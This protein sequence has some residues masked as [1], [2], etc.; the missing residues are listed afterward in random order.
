VIIEDVRVHDCHGNGINLGQDVNGVHIESCLIYSNGL[1]SGNGIQAHG[2]GISNVVISGCTIHSN[3]DNGISG[4]G[5]NIRVVGNYVYGHASADSGIKFTDSDGL[6]AICNNVTAAGGGAISLENTTSCVVTAN[7]V[8]DSAHGI[9]MTDSE[10]FILTGNLARL[11]DTGFSLDGRPVGRSGAVVSNNIAMDNNANGIESVSMSNSVFSGN[12]SV[13]NGASAGDFAGI[14]V[15]GT[16]GAPVENVLMN[17]NECVDTR[18]DPGNNQKYGI[19]IEYADKSMISDS[20]LKGANTADLS[21]GAGVTSLNVDN[22]VVGTQ[23][24]DLT[25]QDCGEVHFYGY[26]LAGDITSDC[27]VDLADLA[28]VTG[29][30]LNCNVPSDPDCPPNWP[31]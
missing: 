30:W 9:E 11:N 4:S 6:L 1:G 15:R 18:G 2:P 22:N 29:E 27:Y 31:Q 24:I 23:Q 20:M 19:R 16:P 12:L 28:V 3:H 21:E 10:D 5:D 13:D 8:A 17:A 14:V 7:Y 26:G 25:P